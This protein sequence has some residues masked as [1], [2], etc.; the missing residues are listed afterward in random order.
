MN[1]V[2]QTDTILIL[3][4]GSAIGIAIASELAEIGTRHIVLAGPREDTLA[5]AAGELVHVNADVSRHAFDAMDTDSHIAFFDSIT[6]AHG[7]LD[8]I[9]IAFGV[10]PDQETA[11]SDPSVAVDAAMVNYVG[12]LSC[13]LHGG[14]LLRSQGHGAIVVLSSVA[15]Q[16][17]RRSN[18]V[19]GSTKAGLDA[20]AEGLGY[21][22]EGTGAH[23]LTV[24]PGFVKSPMTEGLEEAP[25]AVTPAEV[26]R[27]TVGALRKQR[28][29]VWVPSQIKFVGSGMR[30]LPR[31]A[32]KR[33]KA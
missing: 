22:L 33:V 3:G 10:L 23:V 4:G 24:R 17:A 2:G 32:M 12:G 20:A 7:D 1:A 28:S 16:R 13:L 18:F 30:V 8:V 29:V 27:A 15:G 9:V 31:A 25:M 21:A 6:K 11:E 14:N 5:K 26:A 19:Y